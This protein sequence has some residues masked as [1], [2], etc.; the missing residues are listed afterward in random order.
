VGRLI[1]EELLLLCWDDEAGKAHSS[2]SMSLPPALGGALVLDAVMGDALRIEDDRVVATGITT[3]DRLVDGIVGEAT[4]SRRP[5]KVNWFVQRAGSQTRIKDVRDRLVGAGVLGEDTK[6]VLGLFTVARFPVADVA[7]VE[8][9]RRTVRAL[10]LGKLDP[11]TAPAERVLL[12]G[13]SAP[14]KA[15]ERLVD[16]S[17]RK[18]AR[19]RAEAFG[20]GHGI[21][22]AVGQAVQAANV[23]IIAA[24]AAAATSASSSSSSSGSS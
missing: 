24:A 22:A 23:A 17:Q 6:R 5:P 18:A 20:E 12:A 13:L 15:L 9:I 4:R 2:A 21:S 1:A 19:Q 7:V 3:G 14:A 10:L 8:D 16:G 11:E